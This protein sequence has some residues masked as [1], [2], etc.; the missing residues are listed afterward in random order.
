VPARLVTLKRY[1]Q[2]R[3]FR[4]FDDL[5]PDQRTRAKAHYHRLCVGRQPDRYDITAAA[6]QNITPDQMRVRLRLLLADRFTE[7]REMQIS[8]TS[9]PVF[10]RSHFFARSERDP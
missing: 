3:R 8:E 5:P 2:T 9:G 1:Q 6:G 7:T 10:R 4:P